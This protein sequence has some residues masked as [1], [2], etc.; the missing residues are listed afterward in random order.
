M[1]V[2]I[3]TTAAIIITVLLEKYTGYNHTFEGLR[4]TS[5]DAF[6]GTGGAN[7]PGNPAAIRFSV[8]RSSAS[9]RP[10]Q[11]NCQL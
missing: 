2:I 9:L 6:A 4:A 11:D 10:P 7:M 3:I 8:F 1:T 5:A